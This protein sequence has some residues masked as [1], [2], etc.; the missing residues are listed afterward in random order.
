MRSAFS[1]SCLAGATSPSS[2]AM[3]ASAR[4]ARGP[5]IAEGGVEVAAE[6]QGQRVFRLAPEHF[7]GEGGAVLEAPLAAIP[8]DALKQLHAAGAPPPPDSLPDA[9]QHAHAVMIAEPLALTN[10]LAL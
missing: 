7:A 8:L 3:R 1:R 10:F 5:A 6:Q 9:G 2:N 4:G